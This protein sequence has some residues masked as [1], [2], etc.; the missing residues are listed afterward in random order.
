[1]KQGI[2]VISSCCVSRVQWKS[3]EPAPVRLDMSIDDLSI[4]VASCLVS[5][6]HL[7]EGIDIMVCSHLVHYGGLFV[8]TC[9]DRYGTHAREA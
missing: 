6:L 2:Q 7:K 4:V 3:L 5:E 9:R 1:M 8:K